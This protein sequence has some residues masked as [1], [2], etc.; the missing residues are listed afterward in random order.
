MM[1]K[2]NIYTDGSS[3]GKGPYYS[4]WSVVLEAD[5]QRKELYEG[6][7]NKTNNEMEI[8]AVIKGLSALLDVNVDVTIFSDSAYV[9]N[10]M[11]D[12]WYIAWESNGWKN[13]K[14]EPVE[15]KILWEQLLKLV[16]RHSRI[17]FL[18]VNGHITPK[19]IEVNR[20]KFNKRN[21]VMFTEEEF[22]HVVEN[23][24]VVDKL[25]NQGSEE[26]EKMMRG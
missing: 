15:N 8:T 9:V 3:H 6:V 23:N 5:G 20:Q 12:K 1:P 4:G 24:H 19:N 16:R 2:V 21:G 7:Y 17:R 18:H 25:A 10:C 26:I 11:N 13:S 22:A 14:K